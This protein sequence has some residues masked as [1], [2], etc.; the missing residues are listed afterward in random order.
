MSIFKFHYNLEKNSVG[1]VVAI[2]LAASVGGLVEI[3]PLF[4]IDDTV[5]TLPDMRVYTPLEL[6]GRNIYIREGCYACHSQMIRTLRDE[7]ERYGPYSL[8]AESQYDHPMLWG[9]KR[10]GPDIARLGGK[11]SD[12]WHEAHLI[13]PR[14]V[15]PT[16]IMPAYPWLATTPLDVEGLGAHLAV[17]AQL[18]V[19][20]TDDMIAN[21]SRDA[22]AQARPDSDAATGLVDRYGEAT[23]IRRFTDAREVTEM[24]AVIA[25]LQILGQLTQAPYAAE[26]PQ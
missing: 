3:A 18:G 15:V 22:T 4:T 12:D 2:I 17:L 11:Y 20:Y 8:A 14:A 1:F 13:Y 5:E 10:T 16:S 24:D 19:P 26:V 23:T 9:S 6:A 7:V 21:A 25:Y